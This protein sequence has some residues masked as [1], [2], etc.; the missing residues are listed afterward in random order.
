ML[1][2]VYRGTATRLMEHEACSIGLT[3]VKIVMTIFEANQRKQCFLRY[4]WHDC[5]QP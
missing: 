1:N 2:L 4:S 3:L 5:Q